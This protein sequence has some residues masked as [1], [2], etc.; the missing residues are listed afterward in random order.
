MIDLSNPYQPPSTVDVK[1]SAS[2]ACVAAPRCASHWFFGAVTVLALVIS[3]LLLCQ[4]P[5]PRAI[6][7]VTGAAIGGC[8]WATVAMRRRCRHTA[9]VALVHALA[10]VVLGVVWQAESK[11]YHAR[12][13]TIRQHLQ[14]REGHFQGAIPYRGIGLWGC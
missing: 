8:Y 3:Q 5:T 2:Q 10:I 6:V 11:A 7:A 9:F 1:R 14:R 12:I 13:E 4:N